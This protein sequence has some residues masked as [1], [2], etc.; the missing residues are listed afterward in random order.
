MKIE[1]RTISEKEYEVKNESGNI[2]CID[3]YEQAEK[4][5]FSPMQLLLSAA[6]S[7]AAV[8]IVTM[9]KKKRK[10]IH[11]LQATVLGDRREEYPQKFTSISINY[12]LF[13][14]DAT[15]EESQKTMDLA[16]KKY[17]SVI[18]SLNTDIEIQYSI[19]VVDKY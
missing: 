19:S 15:Q 10:N 18:A 3:M 5:H 16:V 17:C 14:T 7:C 8:D 11:D 13:S 1:L 4:K 12:I 9:M 6:V 2:L